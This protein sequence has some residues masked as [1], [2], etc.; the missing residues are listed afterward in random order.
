MKKLLLTIATVVMLSTPV[1]A[2]TERVGPPSNLTTQHQIEWNIGLMTGGNRL[3]GY[4]SSASKIEGFMNASKYF[5]AG[6]KKTE[7]YDRW[8]SCGQA[9]NWAK[10]FLTEPNKG[11]WTKYINKTYPN[12]D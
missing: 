1:M 12:V 3:C 11:I 5:R 6:A 10:E 2:A 7:E 4:F 9:N 8:V